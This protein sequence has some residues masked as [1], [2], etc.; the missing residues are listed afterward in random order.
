MFSILHDQMLE[1]KLVLHVTMGT[2]WRAV[3]WKGTQYRSLWTGSMNEFKEKSIQTGASRFG[4]FFLNIWA[5]LPVVLWCFVLFSQVGHAFNLEDWSPPDEQSSLLWQRLILWGKTDVG[6]RGV[7]FCCAR[8]QES[9]GGNV[10]LRKTSQT[11]DWVSCDR[12]AAM[13]DT[14]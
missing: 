6:L 10:Y 4:G 9:W 7:V 14:V 11:G 13:E 2:W 3:E 5:W 12:I 1:E 8:L